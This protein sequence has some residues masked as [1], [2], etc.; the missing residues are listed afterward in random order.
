MTP[1][2]HMKHHFYRLI[3]TIFLQLA[4]FPTSAQKAPMHF[5]H[6][7]AETGLVHNNVNHIFQDH[8][9]FI[10]I[11]TNGG[12]A[13]YDGHQYLVFKNDE[14]DKNS[15]TNNFVTAIAEDRTGNLW[16]ATSGGGLNRLDRNR[17]DFKAFKHD[18]S[19]PHSISGDYINQLTFDRDGKL[20]LATTGGLDLFDCEKQK[21][22]RHFR[23]D[24]GV[25][26][27]I[28]NNN[29]N[30]V[31]CDRQNNIWVGTSDGLD[32]LDRKR[33][34]FKKF[35]ANRQVANSLSGNDV[36]AIFQDESSRIWVGTNGNGLNI[37]D[38]QSGLFRSFVH[39]PGNTRSLSNNNITSISQCGDEIWVGTENGG[40]NILNTK[41]WV[42][43]KQIHDE[44]DVSSVAGNSVDCIFKDRQGNYWLGI[45]SAGISI[46]KAHNNFAHFQHSSS[47]SSLSH[48]AVMCFY[49]DQKGNIWIGTDG[50]GLNR[51]DKDTHQFARFE[52]AGR[53]TFTAK[54]ILA[55]APEERTRLWIGTWGD[56]LGLVDPETGK[57]IVYKKQPGNPNSLYSNN[58]YAIAKAAD[59][60]LWISTYG[61][62]VDVYEPQ[63][64]TFRHYL[65]NP[66][67][68][69]TLSDNT[70]NCFLTGTNGTMWMGTDEG[71]L[72]RYEAAT[73]SFTRFNIWVGTQLTGAAINHMIEDTKGFLWLATL[74]GIVRFD[75]ASGKIKRYTEIS[76]LIN[77]QTQAIIQDPSG[78]L[79]ISTMNG[80]SMFDPATEKFQNYPVEY[81][82][83]AKEFKQKAAFKDRT[84][85]LYFGGVNGYNRFN[86]QRMERDHGNYPV[87][88]TGL[89]IFNS[90]A[91]GPE[92]VTPQLPADLPE[93]SEIKLSYDQSFLAI[94]YAALDFMTGGKD[95]A[96]KLEGVD[97]QWN[98]V[99]SKSTAIYTNLPP[100]DYF[101]KVK[102]RSSSGEWVSS[103]KDLAITISPPLWATWWFRLAMLAAFIGIVYLLY[104]LRVRA[105]VGQ[106]QKLEALVD[107]RT[108]VVQ[109]QAQELHEQSEH[110]QAL[111][112][113][114]QAQSEELRAQTEELVEQHENAQLARQEAEQANQAKS[115]FL[116]TMS[117]EIRTPMNGV[118][119]MT[120]LLLQTQLTDEQRDY[121]NTIASSG[122]TLVNVINDILDFSKIESGKLDLEQHEF[123]LAETVSQV[124]ELFA[125]QAAAKKIELTCRV[126]A[127]LPHYLIGDSSRLKQVLTNLVGNAIKFTAAGSVSVES[128]LHSGPEQDKVAIGFTVTDT[129]IG[130]PQ[131]KL[132]NLFKAFSQLDSSVN[133]RYGGT[134]LGLAICERL[135]RLM[136]GAIQ[137]QS[138]YGQGSS[139]QFYITAGY[140][141]RLSPTAGM[142]GS[143]DNHQ[144]LDKE[145]ALLHP[146]RILVA[147]DHLVN[148]KFIDYV[149]TKLGYNQTPI[150]E[151]G[152][153]VLDL[154]NQ[155]HF[156]V[157]LMDLQMPEMDGLRATEMI[158]QSR[159]PQPYIVALTANAL[160]E[161]KQRCLSVGMDEYVSKPVK[162]ETIKQI[163]EKA[164][165]KV[166]SAT[167]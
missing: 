119:G 2:L 53:N 33:L 14:L 5:R 70:V 149:L 167:R 22:I 51:L 21:I 104:A 85:N 146:L 108:A 37:L 65:S 40:L 52:Q 127:R 164:A 130:I 10:W 32:L 36:R 44:V 95:Y 23:F 4:S 1:R 89:R 131:D 156:D 30:T 9:G 144:K 60:R 31:F 59:G 147:E 118:I 120:E 133:R 137:A 102:A 148:Q 98:H 117:H 68:I 25:Q 46:Y 161:D 93:L 71:Q 163:L 165:S 29:V 78:K 17:K 16:I 116:A 153:M 41:D 106:Q 94:D 84:G 107:E 75:P 152:L 62:G 39:Q 139:F 154:L 109:Q 111:N 54:H 13:R 56:G 11:G 6:L 110:L 90:A 48:N 42:F 105:M 135:T 50:G 96:Y 122:Q 128:Y 12:L 160:N 150:V 3:F 141:Q 138:S 155:Q 87:V 45:Y 43:S 86:P 121:T 132:P 115:I 143:A 129:G 27:G 64:R 74:N 114:L 63:N 57:S 19:D 76:G 7:S 125:P 97:K 20:W 91:S 82:L 18:P 69:R 15:I 73:D 49:E 66:D 140:S 100:G 55:V 123:N 142:A 81:G 24:P 112:E 113:E 99:G 83:Q 26:N 58:V 151:N 101:F 79:W 77:N 92:G 80:L 124:L 166:R 35:V 61:E 145:F 8:K 38:P 157:I 162:L 126:D 72:N 159:R 103:G 136:G 67:D 28:S 158:R 47:P 88:V 34:T 134:G